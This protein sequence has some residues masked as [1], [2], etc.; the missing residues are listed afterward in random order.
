[1]PA[2]NLQRM[3][4][5]KFLESPFT[6]TTATKDLELSVCWSIA[7][8]PSDIPSAVFNYSIFM[9]PKLKTLISMQPGLDISMK[10][11]SS[12]CKCTDSAFATCLS[13]VLSLKVALREG[14]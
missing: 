14:L 8:L 11:I 13:F 5:K 2:A 6:V 10:K 12:G 4:Q 7:M 9:A 3:L 1:M